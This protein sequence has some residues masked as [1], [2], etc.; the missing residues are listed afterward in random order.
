MKQILLAT[1]L[2]AGCGTT[3]VQESV[4]R[5]GEGF[6]Y[7]REMKGS[8]KADEALRLGLRQIRKECQIRSLGDANLN[9]R[10]L[11]IGEDFSSFTMGFTCEGVQDAGSE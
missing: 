11:D 1:L 9:T 5:K 10:S 4:S 7:S 8:M 3:G 6:M 2:L